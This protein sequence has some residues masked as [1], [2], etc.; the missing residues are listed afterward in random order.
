MYTIELLRN[1]KRSYVQFHLELDQSNFVLHTCKI[2]VIKYAKGDEADEKIHSTFH[3]N[4]S[5]GIPFKVRR[6]APLFVC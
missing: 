2:C 1:K 4:Y 5:I 3:K 6:L